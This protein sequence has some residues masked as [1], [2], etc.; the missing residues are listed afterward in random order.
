[1]KTK[2]LD[3]RKWRRLKRSSYKEVLTSY[4]ETNVLIGALEIKE[5]KAPLTVKI[6]DQEVL[7]ADDHFTWL[8]IMPEN[9]NYSMTVMYNDKN[10]VVQYYFDI[11][12]SH[13]LE[14]G[15]ARRE[16]MYLDVLA[17]PDGRC[18]IVDEDDVV[19]AV[20]YKKM[21][22]RE[23]EF[24]YKIAHQLIEEIGNDFDKFKE[25]AQFAYKKVMER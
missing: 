3:K 6:I 5:V 22:T 1:M 19:R 23:K 16:D 12:K 21:T 15:K 2:Y 10:E 8:Q 9:T 24:A 14:L 20:K 11:N 7:V 25:L 17:L 4:Q 18:E 13:I